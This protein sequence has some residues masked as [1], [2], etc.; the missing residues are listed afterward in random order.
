MSHSEAEAS[1]AID[2][3]TGVSITIAAKRDQPR[4][5]MTTAHATTSRL[6]KPVSTTSLSPVPAPAMEAAT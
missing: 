2:L 6:T 1:E 3:A 4:L 5:P